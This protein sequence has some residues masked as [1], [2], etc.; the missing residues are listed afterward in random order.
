MRNELEIFV[1]FA[2]GYCEITS[3]SLARISSKS[4]AY[5]EICQRSK[6]ESFAKIVNEFYRITIFK[7]N[8]ILEIFERQ[9]SKYAS[10]NIFQ[11]YPKGTFYC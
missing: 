5:S 3:L 4:K 6:V 10:A 1:N 9:G 8:S 11:P 2:G 7:R